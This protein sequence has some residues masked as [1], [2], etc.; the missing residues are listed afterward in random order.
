[1]CGKFFPW[2]APKRADLGKVKVGPH[3]LLGHRRSVFALAAAFAIAWAGCVSLQPTAPMPAPVAR[4]AVANLTDYTWEIAVR[5]PT[6]E[7]RAERLSPRAIAQWNLAEG[8]YIIEQRLVSGATASEGVRS[9]SARFVAGVDY[10]WS[11]ATLQ[12]SV[13]AETSSSRL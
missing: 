11:L 8:D 12:S 1:M 5:A 2:V 10:K 4:V 3:R 13:E 7:P 9:F 6:G